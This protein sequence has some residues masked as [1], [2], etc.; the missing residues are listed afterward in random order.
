MSASTSS[1]DDRPHPRVARGGR[2]LVEESGQQ[3]ACRNGGRGAAVEMADGVLHV[4]NASSRRRR[5][6]DAV[7]ASSQVKTTL[8]VSPRSKAGKNAVSSDRGTWR[9]TV[10]SIGTSCTRTL[11]SRSSYVF[12]EG[13]W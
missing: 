11:I 2:G 5:I 12:V 6:Q 9:V 8:P 3:V 7:V 10:A 1:P 13:R 4:Q